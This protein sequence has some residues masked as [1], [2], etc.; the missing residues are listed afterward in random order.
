MFTGIVRERGT[1]TAVEGADDGVR[2]VIDA[3]TTAGGSSV[4]DSVSISGVCLTAVDV[5]DGGVAFDAVPET[6]SRTTLG[7]LAPGAEV[8]VE[9][10]LRAGEPLGGHYV[11]GHV[12]GVGGVRS[13]A[14]EGGGL[15][16]TLEAPPDL[17][18]Y[19]VVKGSIAV[20]GVS[21]TVAALGEETFD[22]ALVPHT[23][24]ATTLGTLAIGDRVNLEVD[25][26]AK[27]VERLTRR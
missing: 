26:L 14:R 5:V 21:L 2:L 6:L 17:L 18:R 9:P 16:V 20:D 22:V 1:V 10:A 11:Q 13:V 27:Y 8:N 3:P 4:G 19:C 12:D 15:R 7:A 23:L 24:E 25:V